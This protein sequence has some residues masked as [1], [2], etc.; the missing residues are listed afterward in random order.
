MKIENTVQGVRAALKQARKAGKSV[1][2]VPTM[3]NLHHGHITLVAEAKR[4]ADY[5]V[6]SIFVNPTQFGANEDFS[7]YPRTLENDAS[8][9]AEVHCDLLFAPAAEEM[10][11]DGRQQATTV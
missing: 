9:L 1:A 3:G 6:T 10:Y 5:V 4:R 8:M 2:F 11:P 7:S